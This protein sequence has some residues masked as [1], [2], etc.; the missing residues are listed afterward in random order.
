[1]ARR[2]MAFFAALSAATCSAGALTETRAVKLRLHCSRVP[3]LLEAS[4]SDHDGSD[5]D[6]TDSDVAAGAAPFANPGS[7]NS[8]FDTDTDVRPVISISKDAQARSE[9]QLGQE[10]ARREK[11]LQ[12]VSVSFSHVASYETETETESES[13]RHRKQAVLST[14]QPPA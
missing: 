10:R 14:S 9:E 5:T 7:Y 4:G 2:R 3:E 12:R 13:D 6:A 1:M 11:Q 8:A